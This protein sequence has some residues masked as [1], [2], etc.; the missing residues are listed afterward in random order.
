MHLS[1][2]IAAVDT[3]DMSPQISRR[4]LLASMALAPAI[5]HATTAEAGIR[6]RAGDGWI[7]GRLTGA[8]AAV[9]AIKIE[10]VDCV[11]GIP[12]AQENEL[13]DAMKTAG[14]GYLLTT[15][16]FSAACMADGYARA[17]G[18]P[19]V[20]CAV[21]GPGV[22][23][24]LTGLGE[25]R[26]D[27]VPI[28]CLV[29]D[30]AR[31]EKYR[32]FQVHDVNTRPMLD[33][34]C[35]AVIDVSHVCEI[36]KAIRQAFAVA[37][38]GEP[39]PVAVIVPYNLFIET[40]H[41]ESPPVAVSAQPWDEAAFQRCIALLANRSL[42]I[43]IYIGLGCMDYRDQLTRVAEMLQAPVAT[44]VS[45]KGAI[46]ESHPLAVGWGFGPHG[47]TTA[48]AAFSRIDC[49]LAMGVRFSEVST[50][51][52]GNPQ[53][54]HVIHVDV[55]RENLGRIL[56]TDVCMTADAGAFMGRLL[57]V[58]DA[59]RRPS[60]PALLSRIRQWKCDEAATHRTLAKTR[61][62]VDPMAVVLA[63]RRCLPPDGMLFVDVTLSEHLAAEAF[64]TILP[65]TFFN[66]SNNQS[67]GWSI[68]AGIG[69]QK[70]FPGR[71]TATLTG[72][73]CFLM[74]AMELS[75]AARAGL[76]VKFV[77]LDDQT[78]HFMQVLQQAAFKR[79]TATVLA[80]LDYAA[81]AKGLGLAY[82][83]A[84]SCDQLDAT[85]GAAFAHP[86][87]VLIRI[88]TDYGDRKIR[89]IEAVRKRYASE[90]TAAQKARFLARLGTRALDSHPRND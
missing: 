48:E 75:T 21:P 79:T 14:L 3:F 29:G 53:P 57:E 81:L 22:T 30:V 54:R 49:L 16:E 15:H 27:S 46:D 80:H 43:G 20:V 23:N 24:A 32:P 10:G 61:C 70:A 11:F 13:W 4:E 77:V 58:S 62:G 9:A 47:T 26:L 64:C 72:D 83:E 85:L 84:L 56:R 60:N 69:A 19:G 33:A 42:R 59:I 38:C 7:R 74:S 28:V 89:W 52:Y 18:R 17:T 73:G 78:Y 67:M 90:L 88:V 86:G 87:P 44:S 71:A 37:C 5:M 8:E 36:P 63:L 55:N 1:P 40:Y 12:G 76:P 82:A 51:Y 68:P 65:R 50:G 45:G 66:P 6:R 35:K 25:A 41:Y 34:V 2:F 39:G 31:G